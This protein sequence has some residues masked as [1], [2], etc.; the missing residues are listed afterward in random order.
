M[1]TEINEDNVRIYGGEEDR[2]SVAPVGTTIVETLADLGI[3][4]KGL[5]LLG[6][7]GLEEEVETEGVEVRVHQGFRIVRNKNTGVKHTIKVIASETNAVTF[8][9]RHPGSERTTV[10]G[11]TVIKG[12]EKMKRD[13]RQLV[14]DTFDEGVH[15]RRFYSRAEVTER[16]TL[17]RKANEA[18]LY[19]F[20]FTSYGEIIDVTNDPAMAE[21]A[22]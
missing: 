8:G 16:A 3:D 19:E 15:H 1:S 7:D 14:V 10:G 17:S 2:V 6:E 13:E 5:G 18:T 20:T 22:A 9:L 4:Y 12:I 21:D 11:V